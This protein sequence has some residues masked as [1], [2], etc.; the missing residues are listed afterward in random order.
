MP[1]ALIL[2]GGWLGHQ[3]ERFVALA[4]DRLLNGCDVET[5]SDLTVLE[6]SDLNHRDLI[7]PI[8][9]QGELTCEQERGLLR[10]IE[11]G[12]GLVGFHGTADAFRGNPAFHFLLGGSFT[13][14]PGDI[15]EY[16]VHITS[17]S[18]SIT[19]GLS[20]FRVR[21][22]QYYML[23]APDNEILATTTFSARPYPWIAGTIMPVAWKRSWGRG[24]VFYSAIGHAPEDW[25]LPEAQILMQ[26][27]VTWASRQLPSRAVESES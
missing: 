16:T 17:Q 4:K 1:N 19:S 18:D 24:R 6:S 26:R 12:T 23:V 10:A 15:V 14:H 8:W 27:G 7:L 13:A 11:D 3:P 25:D 9:T 22:E 20:D 2:Y 5:T 21:S